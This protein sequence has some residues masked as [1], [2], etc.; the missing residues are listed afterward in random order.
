VLR[1]DSATVLQSA[2]AAVLQSASAAVLLSF[3]AAASD[4]WPPA[5]A[6][7]SS[8]APRHSSTAPGCLPLE[9]RNRHG[10][11]LIPGVLGDVIYRDTTIGGRRTTLALDAFRQPGGKRHP[12]VIVVHGGNGA[13]SRVSFVG[14]LLETLTVAGYPWVSVDYTLDP[15]LHDAAVEDVLAAIAFV[16]C[17]ADGLGVDAERIALLGEDSGAD[18]VTAAAAREKSVRGTVLVGAAFGAHVGARSV[19]ALVIHGG[20]DREV[21]ISRADAWC[22]AKTAS[23]C[24]LV[25]VPGASHR[26]ENWHP[27][28]WTYKPQM[29]AWLTRV[30]GPGASPSRVLMDGEGGRT[31]RESPGLVKNITYDE[32]HGLKLDA[33]LPESSVPSP[34]VILV[35]GGGWEAGDKVT[36]ITP[37]FE[38]LARAG[39]AWFSIDYR[40]TP[41]VR[42]P[43]QMDDLR[44]AV[45]F[46]RRHANRFRVDPARVVVIGE[47]ASGQMAALLAAEDSRLS[48]VVSFYGVY[49]FLPFAASLTPR[50]VPARLFGIRALDAAA[51]A[52]LRQYSPI[53]HVRRDMPPLLLIHGSADEL[54]TQGQ[55]MARALQAAG[56]PHELYALDRAPH[57]MENWEG[58]TEWAGYKDKVVAFVREVTATR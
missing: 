13:G 24:D 21:P 47:S 2:S 29:V 37:L 56:A 3:V 4:A 52:Q 27:T 9:P 40:L 16:R 28:Q 55:A 15:S 43:L 12:A 11:Y 8:A 34:A 1:C 14:Q 45:A 26:V 35:H 22:R 58:R 51:E 31:G 32:T 48:G 17:H 5:E 30:L 10:N 53:A 19:S 20:D 57:G 18:L 33:W 41:E 46:V 23:P 25:A 54:W 49:D 42:H 50:S 38:P 7:R 44:R 39:F 36:Y 6:H